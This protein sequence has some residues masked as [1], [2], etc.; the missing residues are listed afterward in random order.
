MPKLSGGSV[1]YYQVDVLYPTTPGRPAYR[2]E[3]ND[4][5]EA[6]GMNYAEASNFKALWR[7]AAAR[8]GNGK[9]GLEDGV[10]DAEKCV[11]FANRVLAQNLHRAGHKLATTAIQAAQQDFEPGSLSWDEEDGN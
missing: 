4:I 2:A 6:L 11:F 9:P 3:C 7:S 1:D 8:Q 10:Y 5:I